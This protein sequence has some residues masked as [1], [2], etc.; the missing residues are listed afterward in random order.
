[1][2][3]QIGEI[4]ARMHTSRSGAGSAGQITKDEIEA[5]IT[6]RADAKKEKNFA[7]A[8]RIRK[9]LTDRGVAIKDSPQGTTW[10]YTS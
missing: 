10:E 5:L 9:E 6:A 2:L 1:M 7:E 4:R 8:D 3:T